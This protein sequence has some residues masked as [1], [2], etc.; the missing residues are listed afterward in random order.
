MMASLVQEASVVHGRVVAVE[1][2][3]VGADGAHDGQVPAAAHAPQRLRVVAHE[4]VVPDQLPLFLDR[5]WGIADALQQLLAVAAVSVRPRAPS[6]SLSVR[7]VLSLVVGCVVDLALALGLALGFAVGDKAL[8]PVE[9]LLLIGRHGL[10]LGLALCLVVGLAAGLALGLVVG[11]A[12]RFALDL[13]QRLALGLALGLETMLANNWWPGD[14]FVL[15][16]F[17]N[18]GGCG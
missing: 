13:T 12:V 17:F 8:S 14:Q 16:L 6:M 3:G 18:R 11:F 9:R 4:V 10:A 7:L 2:H 1:P 5:H 15:E